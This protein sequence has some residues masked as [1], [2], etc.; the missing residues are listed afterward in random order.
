MAELTPTQ[1]PHGATARAVLGGNVEIYI[2]GTVNSG[3]TFTPPGG[4]AKVQAFYWFSNTAQNHRWTKS[5]TAFTCTA[6]A[7]LASARLMLVIK[8]GT[9]SGG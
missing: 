3:D 7:A 5:A 2:F 4:T 1:G 6:A 8:G 9:S